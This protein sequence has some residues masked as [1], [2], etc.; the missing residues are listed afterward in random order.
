MKYVILI[1]SLAFLFAS[2]GST[3]RV[4]PRVEKDVLSFNMKHQVQWQCPYLSK[5]IDKR[6]YHDYK[7]YRIYTCCPGC[8][9]SVKKKPDYAVSLLKRKKQRPIKIPNES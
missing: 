7:G 8:L 4:Y 1:L 9:E 3:D 6:F 5:E 2:C